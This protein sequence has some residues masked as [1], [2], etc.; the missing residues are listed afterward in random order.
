MNK[1]GGR[2]KNPSIV[3]NS[4]SDTAHTV[5]GGKGFCPTAVK[6]NKGPH[7]VLGEIMRKCLQ[8]TGPSIY[9]P[10]N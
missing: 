2:G 9:P 10:A 4:L 7:Q 6:I 8:L 5:G 1:K 3:H